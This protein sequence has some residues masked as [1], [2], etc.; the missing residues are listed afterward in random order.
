MFCI[1]AAAD[2]ISNTNEEL[3]TPEQ[4]L[5]QMQTDGN[6]PPTDYGSVFIKMFLTLIALAVLFGFTVWFLRRLI[7]YRQEKG[8]GNQAIRVLEKKMISAKTMLYV[9]EIDGKRILVSESQLEIRQLQ[10]P[11]SEIETPS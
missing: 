9:I 5:L 7:R 1:L 4:P 3:L 2:L 10:I 6:L 8:T 11:N